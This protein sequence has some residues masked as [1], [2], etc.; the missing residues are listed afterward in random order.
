MLNQS[1]LLASYIYKNKVIRGRV[2][3]NRGDFIQFLNGGWFERYVYHQLAPKL[4][5]NGQ[6]DCLVNPHLKFPNGD[7]FELDLL[8]V[9][10]RRFLWVECKTGNHYSD[11]L[12]KYCQ[13]GQILDIE[14]E[15]AFLVGL[16][17]S[18]NEA[19][20]WTAGWSITVVNEN[21]FL[22]TINKTL[23]DRE[24]ALK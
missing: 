24:D 11:C 15:R 8:F 21:N 12:P 20:K 13:H 14:K 1:G 9:V 10:D 2:Q 16:G 4:A 17:L 7:K 18:K 6:V 22:S 5:Q 23:I 3:P 19:K